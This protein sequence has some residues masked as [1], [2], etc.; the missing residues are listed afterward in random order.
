MSAEK[1]N[2]GR[3]VAKI[4]ARP[5]ALRSRLQ[6]CSRIGNGG[7][8][9]RTGPGLMPYLPL[10]MLPERRT[11]RVELALPRGAG[12]CGFGI[13]AHDY[14]HGYRLRSAAAF[15]RPPILFR[16]LP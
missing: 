11:L 14:T 6:I 2:R 13:T 5:L 12:A 16:L 9:W 8:A 4:A 10:D 7:R 15:L 1:L 3:M